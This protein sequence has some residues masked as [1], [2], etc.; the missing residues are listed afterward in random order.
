[1]PPKF[2][3]FLKRDDNRKT[4]PQPAPKVAP[5]KVVMQPK[6]PKTLADAEFFIPGKYAAENTYNQPMKVGGASEAVLGLI[7]PALGKKAH[8]VF[9]I[10]TGNP[11]MLYEQK[12]K[13]AMSAK[14]P[15]V[16]F[17]LQGEPLKQAHDL[18]DEIVDEIENAKNN[19]T[20]ETAPMMG[21]I[22]FMGKLF[23]Q[24][25]NFTDVAWDSPFI[26][27]LISVTAG[28]PRINDK[29][30]SLT[31]IYKG[32]GDKFENGKSVPGPLTQLNRFFGGA[33][34]LYDLEHEK[35][36]LNQLPEKDLMEE[37]QYLAKLNQTYK[38]IL[39]SFDA[40]A[41]M[42]DEEGK[43]PYDKFMNNDLDQIV[44]KSVKEG[45]T[46]NRSV[47]E[48]I[49]YMRGCQRAIENGWGMNELGVI[50]H[51]SLMEKQVEL[52]EKRMKETEKTNGVKPTDE[53][54][55]QYKEF[56]K[57]VENLKKNVW[58][59]SAKTPANKAA[60]LSEIDA[61]N[62]K[63][64]DYKPAMKS[65]MTKT[66]MN[67]LGVAKQEM[68]REMVTAQYPVNT[69]D[70]QEPVYEEKDARWLYEAK[71]RGWTDEYMPV[72]YAYVK[73]KQEVEK[74]KAD[75]KTTGDEKFQKWEKEQFEPLK[76]YMEN[77]KVSAPADM[78]VAIDKLDSFR[79]ANNKNMGTAGGKLVQNTLEPAKTNLQILWNKT[80]GL[81]VKETRVLPQTENKTIDDLA[82]GYYARIKARDK[83]ELSQE[84]KAAARKE[85]NARINE[86]KAEAEAEAQRARQ[87]Q[88][89]K[90]GNETIL[91]ALKEKKKNFTKAETEKIF[92]QYMKNLVTQSLDKYSDFELSDP[93]NAD[94]KIFE[95]ALDQELKI[96]SRRCMKPLYLDAKTGQK[97]I[98]CG[99]LANVLENGGHEAFV[100]KIKATATAKV[101]LDQIKSIENSEAL[102]D[103]MTAIKP[104]KTSSKKA[105]GEAY[106]ALEAA[107]KSRKELGKDIQKKWKQVMEGKGKN[108]D[109]LSIPDKKK[110]SDFK[111]KSHAAYE[112]LDSICRSYEEKRK[113]GGLDE[114]EQKAFDTISKARDNVLGFFDKSTSLEFRSFHM[115]DVKTLKDVGYKVDDAKLIKAAEPARKAQAQQRK[116]FKARTV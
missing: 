27:S 28:M 34:E 70:F 56:K 12:S 100:E 90:A 51:V 20:L 79:N 106:A 47:R 44:G 13:P 45:S 66:S 76:D 2:L 115:S 18:M 107:E 39:G 43:S 52:I 101:K 61:F 94:H 67:Y 89:E 33:A 103:D 92:T 74:A 46:S 7:S 75:G 87:I 36:R 25:K 53:E 15:N 116:E 91:K 97:E 11:T 78:L 5:Q 95:K 40:I 58:N 24:K 29:K 83:A 50:G 113:N 86:I 37:T 21:Y 73:L 81:Q 110:L 48:Q 4:D 105:I 16:P 64:H 112:K 96:Y 3:S 57:D 108:L 42:I 14:V 77:K 109:S 80:V 19:V 17:L 54:L 59:V 82:A 93:M 6:V 23:D 88:D 68:K 62:A 65:P 71:Q 1:M 35:I 72:M 31:E 8:D 26:D 85:S 32:L 55:S 111:M 30:M 49:A 84:L 22:T 38:K 99:V 10:A 60:V 98:S 102:K 104:M 114:K 41:D 69:K 9:D 63:Y